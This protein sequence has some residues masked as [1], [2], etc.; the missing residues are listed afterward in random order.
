MLMAVTD[1]P[2]PDSPTTAST[3]PRRI[4]KLTPLTARTVPASVAKLVRRFFTDNSTLASDAPTSLPV[5]T[6]DAGRARHVGR[7]PRTER[8]GP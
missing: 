1:L 8:P 7:R 2:D 3:S 6:S 4:S 5:M